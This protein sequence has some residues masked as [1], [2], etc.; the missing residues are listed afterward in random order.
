MYVLHY[1]YFQQQFVLNNKVFKLFTAR[2][3]VVV[4]RFGQEITELFG[5]TEVSIPCLKYVLPPQELN[6]VHI[7]I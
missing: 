5:V 4:T 3:R 7:C 6:K 2:S 1:H